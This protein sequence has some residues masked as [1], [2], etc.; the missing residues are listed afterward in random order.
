MSYLILC[1]YFKRVM[2]VKYRYMSS[3]ARTRSTLI[4][5]FVMCAYSYCKECT[6]NVCFFVFNTPWA[7]KNVA[8][9]ISL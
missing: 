8:V 2:T 3:I 1:R 5:D 4:T 7:I 9:Y 6:R